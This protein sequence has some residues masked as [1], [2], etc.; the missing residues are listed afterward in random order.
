MNTMLLQKVTAEQPYPLLLMTISGA[1]LYGFPSP[2]SDYDLRGVHRLPLNE[3]AGLYGGR[4]TISNTEMVEETEIDLVTYDIKKFLE[5]LLKKNGLVLEQIYSP[6]V[7]HT[8]PE[9]EELKIM[10][11]QC[12]TR[13]HYYHYY[14]FAESQWKLFIKEQPRRVK[15]LLYIYRV[16]LTGIHLMRSGEVEANLV[17]LNSDF[18]LACIPDLI[19]RKQTGTEQ[20]VLESADLALHEGE[21]LR[22]LHELKQSS[23]RSE[24]P[25][26]P[27]QDIKKWA[28]DFL[29]RVR[30]N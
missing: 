8:T 23:E 15:P 27:A 16:L 12:L 20:A 7:I 9:H 11:K 2:D 3:I 6:L 17:H 29:I 13:H 18:R 14:G 24:L 22:L 5:L 21:Y 19:A 30:M 1:H 28:N 25:D 10:A 4:E 26:S